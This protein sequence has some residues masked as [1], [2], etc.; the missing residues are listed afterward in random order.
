M[1]IK[2]KLIMKFC[3]IFLL[4]FFLNACS[5]GDSPEKVAETFITAG[6][7]K[8]VD[9]VVDLIYLPKEDAPEGVDVKA[10]IKS[11]LAK[12]METSYEK[13]QS[14]GGLDKVECAPIQ[15]TNDDKTKG[16]VDITV[17]FKDNT[18]LDQKLTLIKDNGKWLISMK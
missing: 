4:A 3:S 7:N 11:K 5:S 10:M 17:V 6:Y 14:H 16:I 8:D 15:Y 13:T 18:K 12:S 2:M 1:E 9:T